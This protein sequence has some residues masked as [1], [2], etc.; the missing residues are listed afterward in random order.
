MRTGRSEGPSVAERNP[1]RETVSGN[2]GFTLVE[3]LV[4]I[5]IIAILVIMLSPALVSLREISRRAE[6]TQR[7]GRLALAL[8]QY[9][10]SHEAFPAGVVDPQ[11][12]IVSLPQGLHQGWIGEL[13]PLLDRNS[14]YDSLDRQVSVYDPKNAAVR[15]HYLPAVL[16]PS[17]T[18]G[19]RADPPASNYA[20]CHHD[21]EAQIAED[22][23]GVLFLNSHIRLEDIRDGQEFTL[24][25]GEKEIEPNDLGWLSGTRATLR[26]TGTPLNTRLRDAILRYQMTVPLPE[27]S[28]DA[29]DESAEADLLDD[30]TAAEAATTDEV[31][32][33]GSTDDQ[34]G[35][36]SEEEPPRA[37]VLRKPDGDDATDLKADAVT[38]VPPPAPPGPTAVG[39]F[40]SQHPGGANLGFADGSVRFIGQNVDMKVWQSWG[41]RSDGSVQSERD[42]D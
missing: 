39:G 11:S 19:E 35:E 7:A 1:L 31:A 3:L 38:V 6:C 12:P 9:E 30:V 17:D 40:A 23:H 33:D 27:E 29:R 32:G 18:E 8:Q 25:F 2:C 28:E 37:A 15:Q 34:V 13:L 4:V 36:Q 26:N 21:V 24:L 5:A 16:C 41:H 14:L 22:N 20:G 42:A 10:L